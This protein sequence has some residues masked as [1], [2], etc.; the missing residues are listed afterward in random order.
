M[1]TKVTNKENQ[2]NLE[3]KPGELVQILVSGKEIASHSPIEG[4]IGTVTFQYQEK[5]PKESS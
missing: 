4:M 1:Q 5:E 3:L 2:I